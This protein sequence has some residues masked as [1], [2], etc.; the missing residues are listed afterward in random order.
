MISLELLVQISTIISVVFAALTIR[1]S[2]QNN[3]KQWNIETF[4]AYTQ[5]YES[6]IES[7]PEYFLRFKYDKLPSKSP[8][9]TKSLTKYLNLSQEEFY[10]WRKGYLDE[11]I[12][13]V[14]ESE[15]K[16]TLRSP[17]FRREWS[18]LKS[19]FS[20]K[21]FVRFVDMVQDENISPS[22]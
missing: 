10:L 22:S 15:I 19:E 18:E 14:W 7:F 6:L 21:D 9:L 13:T 20:Y 1:Q 5:R 3:R 11:A 2:S 12:W 4:L 16:R 8:E 17:L